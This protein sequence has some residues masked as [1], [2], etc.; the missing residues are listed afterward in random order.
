[1]TVVHLGRKTSKSYNDNVT[2]I[3]TCRKTQL[4]K[5]VV[6]LPVLL[7]PCFTT[8]KNNFGNN[9]ENAIVVA[10][11]IYLSRNLAQTAA[12]S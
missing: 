11:G 4:M 6:K 5:A 9:F 10:G 1:M 3:K 12:S 8:P 2:T 7:L